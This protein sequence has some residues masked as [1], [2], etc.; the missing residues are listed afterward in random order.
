MKPKPKQWG[1]AHAAMW[2]DASVARAYRHRP[3]Y[4]P[5]T[6]AVLADLVAAP[7][8]ERRVLDIGCGTGYLARPMLAF[9]DRVDAVDASPHM[10]EAGRREPGGGDRRLRWICGAAEDVP[11][12]PPYALITAGASI[13]WMAW[14]RLLPRMADA[15][16]PGAVMA[17]VG[18]LTG[19]AP[20]DTAMKDVVGRYSLNRDYE[21]YAV[22]PRADTALGVVDELAARGLFRVT[23]E[24]TTAPVPYRQAVDDWIESFHARN[25]LSRDRLTADAARACDDGLR[26]A[27]A[28]YARDGVVELQMMAAIV[29]GEPARR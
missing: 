1:L 16:A 24:H 17:V 4:P 12:A 15:L 27:V 19:P 21:P 13:H 14:D 22:R 23:G 5:E 9:A 28:P 7:P 6:F 3:P 2:G 18:D 8:G 20:W 26:A 11:L 29:W 10:I 25:G